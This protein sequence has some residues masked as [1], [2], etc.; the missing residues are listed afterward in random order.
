MAVLWSVAFFVIDNYKGKAVIRVN[1]RY[2]MYLES[3]EK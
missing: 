1:T 2:R 3:K